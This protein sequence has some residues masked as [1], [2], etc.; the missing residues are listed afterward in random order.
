MGKKRWSTQ[1]TYNYL[2]HFLISNDWFAHRMLSIQNKALERHSDSSSSHQNQVPSCWQDIYWH[3]TA[4]LAWIEPLPV[5]LPHSVSWRTKQCCLFKNKTSTLQWQLNCITSRSS[6]DIAATK[7]AQAACFLQPFEATE[8]CS[9]ASPASQTLLRLTDTGIL[10]LA[11]PLTVKSEQKID[12]PLWADVQGPQHL[13]SSLRRYSLSIHLQFP[14]TG[15]P[16]DGLLAP[17]TW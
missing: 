6:N 11:S 8:A 15:P 14:R 2:K 7:T 16:T 12:C 17:G 3:G 4:P 1:N 13:S 10:P 9:A 5:Q